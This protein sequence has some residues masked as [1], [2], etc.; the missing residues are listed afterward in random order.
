M[1]KNTL[2]TSIS[3]VILFLTGCKNK[4]D[5][6]EEFLPVLSIIQNQVTDVDTSL[7]NIRK[8]INVDSTSDTTY[9]KREAFASLATDFLTSPD[10]SGNTLKS[11]YTE[12][13]FFE[14]SINK[15]IITYTPD[16]ED[17][18]LRRQEVHILPNQ[19]DGDKISTI[20]MDKFISNKDSNLQKRLLWQMNDHFQVVT[21][22]QK[23]GKPD[24]TT[25]L[26]VFWK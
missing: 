1:N 15:V 18:E 6:K 13:K 3:F 17:L 21:I 2:F 5:N 23:P 25:T 9:V 26:K 14:E 24:R 4:K 20:I 10:I 12:T 7:Y 22:V 11:H 19:Q 8:I 16:N